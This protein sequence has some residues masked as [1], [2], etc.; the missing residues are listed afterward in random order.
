MYGCTI[1]VDMC[2]I[3]YSIWVP[4]QKKKNTNETML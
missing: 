4:F 3:K 1:C 2:A